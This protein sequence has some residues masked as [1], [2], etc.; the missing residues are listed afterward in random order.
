MPL[1]DGCRFD[2]HHGVEDLRPD[3]VKPNPEQPVGGEEP[4]AAGVLPTQDGHLV[5]QSNKLEL[6]RSAAAYPEREQGSDSGQKGDH[7]HDGT[8]AAQETL[9]LV[10]G[11]DFCAGT[12]VGRFSFLTIRGQPAL[13]RVLGDIEMDDF[14]SRMAEDDQGVEKLKP[15]RYDNK[16]VDGGVGVPSHAPSMEWARRSNTSSTAC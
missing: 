5:S 14:S 6:Q 15:C 4:R 11:F 9:H 12:P 1:D 10:G 13:C 2:Q 7:A 16:H 3:P 8:S